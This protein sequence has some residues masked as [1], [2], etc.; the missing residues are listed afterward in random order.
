MCSSTEKSATNV[1]TNL[2]KAI[3]VMRNADLV[4]SISAVPAPTTNVTEL[5]RH[6]DRKA[7]PEFV[8]VQGAQESVPRN[9]FLGFLMVTNSFSG[10]GVGNLFFVYFFGRLECVG[11]YKTTAATTNMTIIWLEILPPPPP[12]PRGQEGQDFK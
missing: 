3:D 1:S 4:V 6:T 9:R 2:M 5:S 7:E 11:E 12:P 10:H 8:N